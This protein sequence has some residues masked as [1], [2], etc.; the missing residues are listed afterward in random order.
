MGAR[1]RTVG[2]LGDP[3]RGPRTGGPP[4]KNENERALP[5][6]T[7]FI[8]VSGASFLCVGSDLHACAW[9]G[10]WS[11][12][13]VGGGGGAK[14]PQTHHFAVTVNLCSQY[15]N[16]QRWSSTPVRGCRQSTVTYTKSMPVAATGGA[17]RVAP[18]ELQRPARTVS[19]RNWRKPKNKSRAER[20]PSPKM[21]RACAMPSIDPVQSAMCWCS[22]TRCRTVAESPGD[23]CERRVRRYRK[24]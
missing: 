14:R 23:L 12:G 1:R 22:P 8:A 2:R 20:E 17:V 16:R 19:R 11:W 4:C 24:R 5:K 6:R 15:A 9:C 7:V 3:A 10:V 18:A 21:L 13:N